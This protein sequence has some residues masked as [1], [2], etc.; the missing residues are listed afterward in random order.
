MKKRILKFLVFA[1]VLM[2]AS[3]SGGCDNQNT[4]SS[5]S[6]SSS[7]TSSSSSSSV[8]EKYNITCS[9][10]AGADV[11]VDKT[12]AKEGEKVTI[13][14]N[15]TDNSKMVEKVTVGN[16]N[17]TTVE[18]NKTYTFIMGQGN[19][20]VV[21]SLV[22][23]PKQE[24]S[25]TINHDEGIE[26]FTLKVNNEVGSKAKEG[27]EVTLEFSLKDKYVIN[28]ITCADLTLNAVDNSVTFT[29]IDKDLVIEATTSYVQ[30]KF[31]VNRFYHSST[32]IDSISG[33]IEQEEF[34]EGSEQTFSVCV[35][36]YY[37]SI[38][39]FKF[40]LNGTEHDLT[41]DNERTNENYTYFTGSFTMPVEDVEVFVYPV[42]KKT[43][44]DNGAKVTLNYDSSMVTIYGFIDN[45]YALPIKATESSYSLYYYFS[46]IPKEGYKIDDVKKVT[47][48]E[49]SISVDRSLNMYSF[50]HSSSTKELTIEVTASASDGHNVTITQNENVK[51]NH[52]LTNIG[53]GTQVKIN[54]EAL[55]GYAIRGI[56]SSTD[57]NVKFDPATNSLYFVMPK[58]DVTITLNV[59]HPIRF[60]AIE[61]PN[62]ESFY[63]KESGYNGKVIEESFVGDTVYVYVTPKE[64]FEVNKIKINGKE[65]T[66]SS[67]NDYFS[68]TVVDNPSFINVIEFITVKYISITYTTND[69][70]TI[71]VSKSKALP[72]DFVSVT[73]LEKLGYQVTSVRLSTST[74]PLK[75]DTYERGHYS[76][77][78]PSEDVEV[79]V[80]FI[81]VETFTL[82]Y[83]VPS[84]ISNFKLKNKYNKDVK[85]LD[86]LNE[87]EEL[88]MS[89]SVLNGYEVNSV[90]LNQTALELNSSGK[91]EFT[92]PKANST[93]TFD[94]IELAKHPITFDY[95]ETLLKV[96]EVKD[97]TGNQ[98]IS[99]T[100]I[101]AYVGH[102]IRITFA[103]INSFY[104]QIDESLF[105]VKELNGEA[106]EFTNSGSV[107][108]ELVMPDKE[109][110]ISAGV[111][112]TEGWLVHQDQNSQD[113]L[114]IT[115]TSS[116]LAICE[117]ETFKVQRFNRLKIYCNKN[118]D[119]TANE[120]ILVITDSANNQLAE[121]KFYYASDYLE[122]QFDKQEDI[123]FTL[124]ITAK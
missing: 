98:T 76:F 24:H 56:S 77:Y 89:F 104:Y 4:P 2:L 20:T 13:T 14:V 47:S 124:N 26:S 6:F 64:G 80:E 73:V 92:M 97:M 39:D 103:P 5:S 53:E 50:Y 110:V 55:N 120:Y 100:D 23:R 42:H 45:E 94:I 114:S 27:D 111:K 106:V 28:E 9:S 67:Y 8:I 72:N 68:V 46:V 71:S 10:V 84:G 96:T 59:A 70:Y 18:E 91:Y 1:N 65:Y 95:D 88:T 29:M 19:V 25:I 54:I 119:F 112:E 38:L 85:S 69:A 81:Q 34:L 99:L 87:G 66:K 17:V 60:N 52:S 83:S 57:Y 16:L 48:Y 105:N 108:V 33:L 44:T 122:Y 51:V 21:V 36:N 63:V 74:E 113:H 101:Q 3:L 58:N 61:N 12:T 75:E 116:S 11:S 15:V 123:Y 79:I 118:A 32:F 115:N 121:K 37:V 35:K 78:A 86:T 31:K 102:K 90:S 109:I 62:V 93:I 7:N 40:D 82:E 41:I 22:D 49:S 117:G 30:Q 43:T 107:G